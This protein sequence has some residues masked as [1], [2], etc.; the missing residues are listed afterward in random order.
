MSRAIVLFALFIF[1]VDLKFCFGNDE[2][3][4]VILADGAVKGDKYWNGEHY[5]F[6]GIP[7]A[8]APTGR[9]KFQVS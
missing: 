8:K 6:C 3:K 7:Y 9:D 1:C 5:E 4:I 2:S